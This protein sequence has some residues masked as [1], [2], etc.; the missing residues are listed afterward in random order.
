MN[1]LVLAVV[2]S[3]GYPILMLKVL[4]SCLCLITLPTFAAD[5]TTTAANAI[6]SLGVDLLAKATKPGENAL[7]S[8]Y[9][10]QTALAMTYAGADGVTRDEMARVLHFPKDETE[11][12]SSFST[13]SETLKDIATK[14]TKYVERNKEQGNNRTP[15]TLRVANRL[16]GQSGYEFRTAFLDLAKS[17]YSAP[18]ET[19]DFEKNSAA[20]L[21]RINEWVETQTHQRIRNLIPDGGISE[22]TRLVLVNAIFFKASWAQEFLEYTTKPL[23]FQ[24]ANGTSMTVS[25]MNKNAYFFY[26]KRE[27]YS[28]VG[29]P[30]DDLYRLSSGL[31]RPQRDDRL[32]FLILLPDT[33]NGLP[34]LEKKL[35]AGLLASCAKLQPQKFNLY[36][37]KFRL[38]SPTLSLGK[39]LQKLGMTSAFNVPSGT[40]NFNRMSPRRKNDNLFISDVFHKTFLN[41]DEGGTEAA[42]ATAVSMPKGGSHPTVEVRIDRPFLFAIQHR[43]SGACLFLGRMTDP[44]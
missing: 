19:I 2:E 4:L 41:L 29:L 35:N 8:P 1:K 10:I 30:Y 34:A 5:A 13:L 18:F 24:L 14:S 31:E 17:N 25:T 7:L 3:V 22:Q 28:V 43:E 6:N 9:S 23:P 21:K 12:H 20:E 32:Q 26:D 15:I 11:M 27:G 42:A 33:A 36:L 37:P 40:A 39:S 38:E 16:F 44:R